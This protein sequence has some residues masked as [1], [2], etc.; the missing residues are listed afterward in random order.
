[1]CIQIINY[2]SDLEHNN[3]SKLEAY[4]S[5]EEPSSRLNDEA[6]LRTTYISPRESHYDVFCRVV[7]YCLQSRTY[8]LFTS[9]LDAMF[10]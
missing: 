2:M 4:A 6:S 5:A 10:V 7:M 8:Y 3:D 9:R 1:M